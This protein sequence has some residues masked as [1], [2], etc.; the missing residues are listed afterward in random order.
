MVATRVAPRSLPAT[1]TAPAVEDKDES[2]IEERELVAHEYTAAEIAEWTALTSAAGIEKIALA[3]ILVKAEYGCLVAGN[4]IERVELTGGA[5]RRDNPTGIWYAYR[6]QLTRPIGP[7]E[8]PETGEV[9]TGD[10]GDFALV[11]ETVKLIALAAYVGKCIALRPTSQ[12]RLKGSKKSMWRYEAAV[13]S[14]TPMAI[15]SRGK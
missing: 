15:P 13:L 2:D 7:V 10:P 1:R 9:V 8:D 14:H 11:P 12:Q 6:F 3:D 5:T 4:L